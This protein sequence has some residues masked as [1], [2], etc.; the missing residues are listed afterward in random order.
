MSKGRRRAQSEY[1]LQLADQLQWLRNSSR[2]FDSGTHSEGRRIAATLRTIF[3]DGQ[4]ESLLTHLNGWPVKVLTTAEEQ[5]QD[6]DNIA[7]WVSGMVFT[8]MGPNPRM[9][10]ALSEARSRTF[11]SAHH[12]WEQAITIPD[13]GIVIRR[14]D[15]ILTA[16]NKDGGAHVDADVPKDYVILEG[17]AWSVRHRLPSGQVVTKT[18]DKIHL[19]YLRQMA[20][21]VLNSPE[22]VRLAE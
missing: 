2:E 12:W 5:K 6:P 15:L 21:E 14:R 22:L 3:R 11:I 20:Y 13:R 1:H 17:P 4:S 9:Q 18:L 8:V 19:F 16:T 7:W 10:A